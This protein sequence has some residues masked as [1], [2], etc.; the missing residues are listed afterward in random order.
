MGKRYVLLRAGWELTEED[1]KALETVVGGTDP[2]GKVIRLKGSPDHVVVKADSS[3]SAKFRS[4]GADVRVP[5]GQLVSV[6]TSGAI[7][8]LKRA[9]RA[10]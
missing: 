8:N 10:S 7:V 5:G 2:K 4:P 1:F 9:L 6:L 3:V